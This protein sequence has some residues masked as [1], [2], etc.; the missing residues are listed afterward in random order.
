MLTEQKRRQAYRAIILTQCFGMLTYF[1]FS[2]GFYLNYFTKLGFSSAAFAM[3][4]SLP[5]LL[6]GFL[7]LPFAYVS[8]RLGKL[9][10]ALIGQAGLIA[11]VLIMMMAGWGGAQLALPLTVIALLIYCFGMSVQGSNWFALLNP[12]I[13]AEVRGRFFGRLRVT[14]L[15]VNVL[16]TLLISGVLKLTQSMSAFQMLLGIVLIAHVIRYFTYARIPELEREGDVRGDR[17]SFRFAMKQVSAIPGYLAFNGY[18]FLITLFTAG[19]P[20]VFNLMQKDVFA[21]SESAIMVVGNFFLGGTILGCWLGGLSVDRFGT[22][23]ALLASHVSYAAVILG[24]LARHWFP[25]PLMI[26]VMLCSA[27]FSMVAGIAGVAITSEALALI[28]ERNKSLS[29][30]VHMVLINWGVALA[31]LFIS[32]ALRWAIFEGR[33]SMLGQTFTDYDSILLLFALLVFLMLA[34]IGLVPKVVRKAQILPGSYP[35]S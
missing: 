23:A 1:L 24:M 5:W 26:H 33:W 10:L 12:I 28:P 21:F 14:F 17:H 34:A 31:G 6:G 18:V 2:N 32:W 22:R 4:S 13:P 35:R 16:F 9:K 3:L 11:S 29:T 7:L 19:V 25:W 30:A 27:L 15:T 20:I 8:D